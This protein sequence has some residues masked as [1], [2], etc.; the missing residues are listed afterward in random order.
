MREPL[1]TRQ[2]AVLR[3]LVTSFLGSGDPVGSRTLTHLL[4][5]RLSPASV[6]NTLAELSELGL[7]EKPHASAGRIPSETGLR[8]FVD[9]L[10]HRSVRQNELVAYKQRIVAESLEEGDEV[11]WMRRASRLLSEHTGQLGFVLTPR[12]ERVPLAHVSLVRLSARRVLVVLVSQHGDSHELVVDDTEAPDQRE[13]ERMAQ[14][15]NER[16][17]G[18]TLEEVCS[19]L[20]GELAE[21]RSEASRLLHQALAFGLRALERSAQPQAELVV[22]TRLALL[23][24]PEFSDPGLVREIFSA[25][26][27]NERLVALLSGLL[28][29]DRVSVAL[30]DE[31]EDPGLHHCALVAAPYGRDP[32]GRSPHGVPSVPLGVLGVI[33]SSRMDYPRVIPL[34]GYCSQLVTRRFGL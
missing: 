32:E 21:L 26:E 24:Q 17:A 29:G 10:V 11:G 9:E 20:E 16:V 4:P 13:L 25:V 5:F 19:L 14:V 8:R 22:A 1:S 30:G 18:R 6:R 23:E 3:A 15:L 31:L 27:T 2:E 7:I 33:G 34:V 28:D 12:L